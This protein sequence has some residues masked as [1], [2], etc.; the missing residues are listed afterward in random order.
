[1]EWTPEVFH[2]KQRG[3][4]STS[5][6]SDALATVAQLMKSNGISTSLSKSCMEI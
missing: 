1:M 6:I 3:L 5:D 4:V 2:S